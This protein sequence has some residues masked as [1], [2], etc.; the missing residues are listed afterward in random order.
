MEYKI[1]GKRKIVN[2]RERKKIVK[3]KEMKSNRNK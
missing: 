1:K 3:M 2:K